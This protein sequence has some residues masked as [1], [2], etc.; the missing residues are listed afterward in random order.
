MYALVAG[1]APIRTLLPRSVAPA[2]LSPP[3]LTRREPV[4]SHGASSA[5]T[6]TR[7]GT[8][9]TFRENHPDDT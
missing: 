1:Q 7:V 6:L 4:H 2:R 8:S 9:R 5:S 3:S